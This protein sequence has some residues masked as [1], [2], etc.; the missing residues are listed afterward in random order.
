MNFSRKRFA[1]VKINPR[2]S[3][4][5]ISHASIT[6]ALNLHGHSR[7]RSRGEIL[8][9]Q[10]FI[11]HTLISQILSPSSRASDW[12]GFTFP[13]NGLYRRLQVPVR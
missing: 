5:T 9:T 10:R 13:L 7:I 6:F 11:R 2:P 3:L 1:S 4:V 8:I 12:G